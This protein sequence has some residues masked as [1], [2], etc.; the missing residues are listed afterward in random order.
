MPSQEKSASENVAEVKPR[1]VNTGMQMAGRKVMS[2]PWTKAPAM[3]PFQPP[4]ALPKTPAVAPQKKCGTTPGRIRATGA[5]LA[6]M[7][8]RTN[9]P[10]MP[11]TKEVR[12]PMMTALGA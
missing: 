10:T 1:L 3:Q 9:R 4:S 5:R 2:R 7:A 11:A 8:V 12:K 6:S